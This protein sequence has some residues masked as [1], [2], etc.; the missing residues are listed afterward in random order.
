MP[1]QYSP[2]DESSYTDTTFDP[3]AMLNGVSSQYTPDS[4]ANQGRLPEEPAA[5]PGYQRATAS[6]A[7]PKTASVKS[8]HSKGGNHHQLLQERYG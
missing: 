8:S 7:A 5:G 6:E 2:I 1:S 3:E 4:T